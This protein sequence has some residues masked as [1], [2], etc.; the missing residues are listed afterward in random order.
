MI[1]KLSFDLSVAPRKNHR[2]NDVW[3]GLRKL[4]DD[5]ATNQQVA[6]AIL[7]KLG[8]QADAVANGKEAIEALR[9]IPYY[10]LFF[11]L[12]PNGYFSFNDKATD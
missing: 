8:Y 9:T 12:G 6:F 2:M 4:A 11:G 3:K 5:N 7:R 10:F 1:I